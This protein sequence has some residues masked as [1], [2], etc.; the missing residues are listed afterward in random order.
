MGGM[1]PFLLHLSTPEPCVVVVSTDE[2]LLDAAH[3]LPR[4]TGLVT[5]LLDA[6]IESWTISRM[7]RFR[8][9]FIRQMNALVKGSH[10]QH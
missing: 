6:C 1:G 9:R 2:R 4:F 5:S 10:L 3:V 7:L 8:R